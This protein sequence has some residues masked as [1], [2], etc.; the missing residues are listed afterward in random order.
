MCFNR[1]CFCIPLKEGVLILGA[2]EVL[3]WLTLAYRGDLLKFIFV[4]PVVVFFFKMG[5]NDT[6]W[7][8]RL[9]FWAF[10]VSRMV[11]LAQFT[12]N[13]S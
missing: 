9:F 3:S 6:K 13:L 8:R 12:W 10:T 11:I 1:C 2:L 4:A 5:M 7:N